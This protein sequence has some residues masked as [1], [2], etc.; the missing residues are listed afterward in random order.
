M[1]VIG[2]GAPASRVSFDKEVMRELQVYGQREDDIDGH[3]V[4]TT[5]LPEDGIVGI[6]QPLLPH[7]DGRSAEAFSEHVTDYLQDHH[8]PLNPEHVLHDAFV[9]GN[10]RALNARNVGVM[11]TFARFFPKKEGSKKLAGAYASVG[12]VPLYALVEKGIFKKRIHVQRINEVP[13]KAGQALTGEE[14]DEKQIITGAIKLRRNTRFLVTSV[15]VSRHDPE[16]VKLYEELTPEMSSQAVADKLVNNGNIQHGDRVVKIIEFDR[17]RRKAA[18]AAGGAGIAGAGVQGGT[19][20]GAGIVG[21]RTKS[22]EQKRRRNRNL[23]IA[24]GA[25]ALVGLVTTV[26]LLAGHDKDKGGGAHAA[27]STTSAGPSSGSPSS[28]SGSP[29]SSS[30]SGSGANGGANNGNGGPGAAS[31]GQP[32]GPQF[33]VEGSH[34]FSEEI[35]QYAAT[36]GKTISIGKGYDIY[37]DAEHQLPPNNLIVLPNGDPGTYR[38]SDGHLGISNPTNDAHWTVA[39]K[40]IIDNDLAAA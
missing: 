25:V 14:V 36:E 38:M 37:L 31:V 15:A 18:A 12:D 34:G 6:A 22:P 40:Q 26:V 21:P 3:N 17:K 29:E 9:S 1:T 20:G 28:S 35:R 7:D 13:E 4:V 2:I 24:A 19:A 11:A 8:N 27:P 30:P 32:A 33:V 39:M 5:E 10:R 16:N 23:L